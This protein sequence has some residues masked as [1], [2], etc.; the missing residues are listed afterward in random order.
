MMTRNVMYYT[1]IHSSL[2]ALR[3][4]FV[5]LHF[6]FFARRDDFLWGRLFNL[7]PIVNRPGQPRTTVGRRV[8]NPPQDAI[9]PHVQRAVC[10]ALGE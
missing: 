3:R 2:R 9:L 6:C 4:F 10:A 5:L 7:R 1:T 8:A